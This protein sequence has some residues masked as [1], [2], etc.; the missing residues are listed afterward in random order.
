MAKRKQAELIRGSAN[1]RRTE[2][3]YMGV[4]L[5]TVSLEDWRG[6]VSGALRDAK[7]GD[8]FGMINMSGKICVFDRT[9]LDARTDQ[10]AASRLMLSSRAD[11]ALLIARALAADYPLIDPKP[12]L[13]SFSISPQTVCYVGVD[14]NPNGT[15]AN[16]LNL[17]LGPTAVP[18]A[19]SW[20]LIKSFFLE[21]LCADNQGHCHYLLCYIAHAL[22]RPG[23][24]PGV[25]IILISGQGTGKGTLARILQRTWSAT[26]LQISDMNAITGSFNAALERSFIVFADEAL[27]AGDRRASDALKSLVTEPT[28]LIN[29][30]HQP[31]RQVHSF[32]RFFAATKA[33]H[34][35]ATD[36]DDRRDFTLRVSECRKG[37][38]AY[39]Q[40]LYHEIEHGGVEAMVHDLL[41][42]DLSEF[43]VR[44]KPDT[45]ELLEQKLQSLDPVARWWYSCLS[46]GDLDADGNWPEF[47]ATEAIINGI[48]DL[49]GGKMYRK[50]SP[51]DAIKALKKL[52]PSAVPGQQETNLGRRRGLELPPLEQARAEFDRY[53]GAKVQW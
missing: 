33:N 24:K 15:S 16:Y 35:K 30:K 19:G 22:Q 25:M 3:D 48:C 36:R 34:L 26:F 18:R 29:E 17:W 21:V 8:R 27:F 44:V 39:W 51:V 31:A 7:D 9:S 23:E 1:H 4:L 49:N 11:G 40:A 6:V 38:T 28:I 45:D 14:F 47:V 32:H 5:D 20:K 10:G 46:E 53:I 37:D 50:S 12:I 2:G 13:N 43:N 42:M 52:C 41:A